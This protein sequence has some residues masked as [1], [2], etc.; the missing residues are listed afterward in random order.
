[1]KLVVWNMEWLNDLVDSEAGA[2]KPGD[3]NVRGPRLPW[4][5]EGPSVAERIAL[6][7]EE[8]TDLDPD[9]LLIIEGPDRTADMEILMASISEVRWFTHIQRSRFPSSPDNPRLSTSTQ[10]VGIAVRTDRGTFADTH[11]TINDVED[12]AAGL[13]HRATEPFFLDRGADR[14]PEWFRYERRP[15]WVTVHPAEGSDFNIMGVHLKSKGIFG[16]Y[17]WS[18]W[19]QLADANCMRLLAQCRHMREAFLEVY[20]SDPAALPLIV[21]GD[22]NDAVVPIAEDLQVRFFGA[23]VQQRA[24]LSVQH[25]PCGGQILKQEGQ[26]QQAHL[27]NHLAGCAL[28]A[29][30]DLN[31]AGRG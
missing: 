26:T 12:P 21:A 5:N 19:W 3:R 27:G 23:G 2:L 16:A 20:L 9:I 8:L 13:V 24:D 15:L 11:L 22:I 28:A 29:G 10:C 31:D 17:E 6:L 25:L 18:R 14:V 4:K 1:M 30:G 7:R